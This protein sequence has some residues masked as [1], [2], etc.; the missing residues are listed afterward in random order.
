MLKRL[1]QWFAPKARSNNRRVPHSSV[2]LQL[3][4]LEDRL[5]PAASSISFSVVNDWG[6]GFQ[7]QITITDNTPAPINNWS[8]QFNFN[9]TITDLWNGSIV[10][11]SGSQYVVGNAGYDANIA[12]GQSVTI[13][14]IASPGNVTDKPTNLVLNYTG[15]NPPP[16]VA[17]PAAASQSVVT[18]NQVNLSV[19]GADVVG[20]SNLTYTWASVGTP[21]APVNF[22]ANGNN[23][24][25][26]T[27]ATF[28]A[29]GQYSF[30]V[31]IA[32]SSGQ[33]VTSSVPVTVSPTLSSIVVSPNPASVLTGASQQFKAQADDQF[34]HALSN[35]P[36]FTWTATGGSVKSSGLYTAPNTPGSATVKATTGSFS[37][38]SAV[39]VTSP[40]TNSL[41]ATA[42][43]TDVNDWGSG[44]TGNIT[45]AN[46]GTSAINGWTLQ[47]DFAGTIS[48][49]WNGNIISHVG[50]HYAIGDAGYNAI[51]GAGQSVSFGF[52]GS[53]G[54]V[55][56]GPANYILNGVPLGGSSG[57]T[58]QTPT[59][60][61]GNTSVSEPTNTGMAD[62]FHTAG[63]QI[64]DVN[65]NPVKIAG[66]NWFGFETTT[67]VADGLWARNYKDMMNQMKQ[68][69]FNTIRIP[70]SED[71]FN[72]ANV[73]TSIN[74]SLNPD[75]QGLSSLQILDKIVDYA[76]QVGLRIILDQH[77]AKASN[78]ANEELWYIPG[79][80][81]YT[82]QAWI[83]DW[84]TLAKRYAGNATVIGA[85]LHN[86]S[87]G[88]ATWGDGNPATDWRMAAQTAGNAILA[89]NP[90]WLIFVEGI[91]TYNGQSTWWGG[92]LMGAGKNPVVLNIANR[93]VYSPHDY[94]A[95]VFNQTWFSASNY[96]NN[97]P[98][99][100]DQYWGY[101]YRQD[102]APVWLG[103]FGSKLQTTSDQQWYQQITS[104]L[105]NTSGAPAGGTGM[106]W[107]WWSWN[108]NSGDTGGILQDDWTTVNQNKVQGLIPIEF[109]L[110]P[111]GG[112]STATMTFTLALNAA[113]SQPVA[114][115][116]TTADGTAVAGTDYV[117]QSGTVTFAPGQT[118]ATI[119][120]TIFAD[121]NA[122]KN[123]N[124]YLQLSNPVNAVLGS[125]S[126]GTGT[127]LV[128]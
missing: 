60:S 105:A 43:F 106:S 44:F 52:N 78:N 34:G 94:P 87:H 64:V 120:V 118:Q 14:F 19:L 117:A 59:I 4:K 101:L 127:I 5:I 79:S 109:S 57:G 40:S 112:T 114:V 13:G 75:L 125:T 126:A 9:H 26:N 76:G 111:A 99:I 32:D 66:V 37:G 41:N 16:T 7:G 108:P 23:A 70:Y 51:I 22:S 18:G 11:H 50:N 96:P 61:I 54:N 116:F 88:A 107:T 46:K 21:P 90:N 33:S 91:Q 35:Q 92:N 56:T 15:S 29:A 95:S 89:V 45:I 121:P 28:T 93:V 31:T 113:I 20:E 48:Q 100:W 42:A 128:G 81:V 85:D 25:K 84:V 80:A 2:V 30:Q 77:S 83:N 53:P 8:L 55:T 98:G 72:P 3:E 104:Y 74:Y 17:K 49:I 110:P 63:N 115:K 65:G 71:I 38:S 67:F 97:L 103:E 6:S 123:L 62:F 27:I 69:G 86:E 68:L 36:S 1:F 47:F 122:K 102:I 73:P 10:S 58:G 82:Q 119:L 24:A 124:F 39:T 12:P